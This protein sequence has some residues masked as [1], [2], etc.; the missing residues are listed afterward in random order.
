MNQPTISILLPVRNEEKSIG[1]CLEHIY[2]Q[3]GL[4]DN[5]EVIVS[6]GMSTD[7]TREIIRGYQANHPNLILIDNPAKIVPVGLNLAI[8]RSMGKIIIRVDGHTIIAP[9][10]VSQCVEALKRTKADNVGGKMTAIGDNLFGKAVALATSTPFGV[11][12]AHFHYSDNEEWVDTVYMG[13]WPR[14]VFEEIG[15]FDEEL[16]RDQ[17][18]EFNYRLREQG[19]RILL[20]PAIHSEYTVRSTPRT[21]WRQYYQ[22]GYWKVRVLQKHPRQMSLRQF[23]PPAFVLALLGSILLALFSV[24]HL[25]SSV[26]F[27]SLVIPLLYL[28]V[29]LFASLY[30]AFKR[31]WSSLLFLPFIFVILHLS[32]GLGFLVGLLKFANR[33]GDKQGRTPAFEN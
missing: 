7:G 25:P 27:L 17:D 18:D 2:R 16:V 12:G 11:G 15:L 33:W 29:N 22:Y 28:I 21:L 20:S 24:F 8:Q 26:S 10:Y 32:Y 3:I 31:G 30:T 6:D 23:V 4:S 9:D 5:V 13:A 1:F 14:R 19:G